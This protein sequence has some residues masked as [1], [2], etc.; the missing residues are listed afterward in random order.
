MKILRST[1]T[2][3]LYIAFEY[4]NVVFILST[5]VL[6]VSEQKKSVCTLD[7]ADKS[8][9]APSATP[10]VKLEVATWRSESAS[11]S[12]QSESKIV[13]YVCQKG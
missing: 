9:L 2:L 8:H 1:S 13:V 3:C 7:E 11:H 4:L 6:R 12:L 10:A 5:F